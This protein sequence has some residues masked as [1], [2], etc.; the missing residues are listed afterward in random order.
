MSYLA[1]N[2][3][4]TYKRSKNTLRKHRI[5]KIFRNNKDIL[6]TKPDK[7]NRA[8]IV[9]RAL[10]MSSLFEIINDLSKFS[11]DPTIRRE[12]KIQGFPRPLNK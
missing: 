11:S 12:G 9:N 5:I 10:Y 1:N 4:N 3:V 8:I 2:Y 7:D 6:I